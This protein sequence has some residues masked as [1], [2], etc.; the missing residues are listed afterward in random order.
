MS[1]FNGFHAYDDEG[2]YLANLRDY[3][4]GHPLLS[5]YAQVYGPFFYEVLAGLFKLLGLSPDNDTG[6][7]VTA[8]VWLMASAAGGLV[9]LIL[10]RNL[11][12]GLAAEL[13]TFVELSVLSNEP[14]STYGMYALLLLGITA[15]A[16]AGR[17]RPRAS[18]AAIGAI[19]GA[20]CLIKI[21][22]GAFAAI[23]VV[24]A[25]TGSLTHRWRRVLLPSMVGAITALPVLLTT[26][27]LTTAWVFEFAI[28]VAFS[29]AAVGAGCLKAGPRLMVAPQARWIVAGGA[30]LA[31]ACFGVALA[32]GTRPIDV[33]NGLVVAPLRFPQL[34]TFP[35][36][37]NA[38]YLLVAAV[39]FSAV[40]AFRLRPT[41]A[42]PATAA[43]LVRVGVGLFTWLSILLLPS[44]IFLLALP[45]AWVATQA[46][47][48]EGRDPVGPYCRLLLPALAVLETL[49]AYPIAGSQLSIAAL[50]LVPIGV[51]TLGDGIRQ[52]RMIA[53]RG[54][55]MKGVGLVAPA[56][57]VLTTVVFLVFALTVTAGFK[58]G[59][60][61]GVRGAE[62]VRLPA[63][64]AAQ[65]R[66]LV[67]A[68]NRDCS[69]FVTFPGMNSFYIWTAQD[70]PTP[71]RVEVW[72]LVLDSNQQQSLVQQLSS[73]PRMCVIK[74]QRMIEMW[75]A[76]RQVPRTPLV[77]FIDRRF[78]YGGSYGDYEL[79][80]SARS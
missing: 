11:L 25:W 15:A 74:N 7:L 19:V 59:T 24:F 72:W 75:A 50:G 20:L 80:V 13:L 62:S 55:T 33:W 21:N 30:V 49:Q 38:G 8:V 61:L 39:S 67:S 5:P 77:D 79:L 43:G 2:Y 27:L 28:V 32:G 17:V 57:A 10:S 4:A 22:V 44:S 68:V 70:P 51:I 71:V 69:S 76:G 9:A 18:G 63:Q 1:M 66:Q 47:D 65:V 52:L 56:A 58:T 23:A 3:L 53:G 16:C 31:V 45:L 73:K 40:L 34:F 26:S 29:A 14:M 78:V 41:I 36:S 12:L 6:R 46:P 37:L 42:V 60:P 64:R 54:V 35:I 48:D